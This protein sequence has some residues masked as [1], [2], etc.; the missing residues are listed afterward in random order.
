MKAKSENEKMRKR[1]GNIEDDRFLVSFFYILLRDHLAAG[2]VE[3][4]IEEI[5]KYNIG[6]KIMYTN[7]YLA[8]YAQDIANRLLEE[9]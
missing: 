3:K 4:I 9:D 8:Q 5:E 7:G 1:S 6:K 2:V